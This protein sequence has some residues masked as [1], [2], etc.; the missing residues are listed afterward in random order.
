[1]PTHILI[2]TA[3]RKVN[4]EKPDMPPETHYNIICGYWEDKNHHP[5]VNNK[6][7]RDKRTTK[8]NDIETGEDQ[9]GE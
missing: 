4:K 5:L 7:F 8:K 1:M 9:K 2:S 3:N 6:V